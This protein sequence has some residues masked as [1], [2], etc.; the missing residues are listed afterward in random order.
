MKMIRASHSFSS[1]SELNL[2]PEPGL[3]VA[4]CSLADP[5]QQR[6]SQP[7]GTAVCL[8]FITN[9]DDS[10]LSLLR[11]CPELNLL[12][13]A[14]LLAAGCSLADPVRLTASQMAR[15]PAGDE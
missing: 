6:D 4:G 9:A 12:L 7:K 10:C 15:L 3:Q 11:L 8:L 14:G 1:T 2:L 5:L 13:E